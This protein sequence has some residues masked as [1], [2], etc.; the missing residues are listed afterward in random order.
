MNYLSLSLVELHNLIVS[1]KVTPE[2]LVKD[3]LELAKKDTNNAFEYICEKEAIEEIANGSV[4]AI[5]N[6]DTN[7]SRALRVLAQTGVI[8]LNPD[9]DA[10]KATEKDVAVNP[11]NLSF[12]QVSAEILP[13]VL[14]SV[15]AAVINGNYAIGAGLNLA[16]AIYNEQLGPGYFNVIAV[17]TEDLEKPFT[18]DIY[19][20]VHSDTF[21]TVIDDPK[22]QYS[23]FGKPAGYLD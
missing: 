10:A 19:S 1:G 22:K 8:G 7:L 2:Q 9:I 23:A 13:S 3:S 4:I 21:R 6:D 5:P 18:K 11:K 20:I 12:K 17:R 16:D 15:G 14:D